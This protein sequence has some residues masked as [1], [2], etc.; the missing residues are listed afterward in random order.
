MLKSLLLSFVIICIVTRGSRFF[1]V[2]YLTYRYGQKF[3]PFLEK[4]GAKWSI[5][6]ATIIVFLSALIYLIFINQ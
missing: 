6:I 4:K 5:I 1:L 3:G 2:S